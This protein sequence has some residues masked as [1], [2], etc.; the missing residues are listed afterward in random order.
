MNIRLKQGINLFN[1][2]KF[3]E[4]HETFEDIWKELSSPEKELFQGVIQSAVALYLIKENRKIGA[5]KVWAR[6][7]KNFECGRKEVLGIDL[8]DLKKQMHKIFSNLED[9]DFSNVRIRL[10]DLKTL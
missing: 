6:A 8:E 2:G 7:V 9:F 3:F 1:K 4:A 5:K 10:V